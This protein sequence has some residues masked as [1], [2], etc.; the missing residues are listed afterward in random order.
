MCRKEINMKVPEQAESTWK[1][2]GS[3]VFSLSLWHMINAAV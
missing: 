1:M 2:T 3:T